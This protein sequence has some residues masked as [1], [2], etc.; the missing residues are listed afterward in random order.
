MSQTQT[1][2]LLKKQQTKYK[3]N[4]NAINCGQAARPIINQK[5][6]ERSNMLSK[7]YIEFKNMSIKFGS[8]YLHPYR[9][10]VMLINARS[11]HKN[12]NC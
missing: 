6:V 4:P 8:A 9:L 2:T 7:N 11:I 12:I 3:P 10:L 5:F 1:F